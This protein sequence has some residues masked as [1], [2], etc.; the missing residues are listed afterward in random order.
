MILAIAH[1]IRPHHWI[2]NFFLFLPIFFAGGIFKNDKLWDTGM[3][4][5]LF[6]FT[7]SAIYVLN[8][9][10]DVKTDRLHPTKKG[11]PIASGKVPIP[12][13]YVLFAILLSGSV[14][15]SYML[16]HT[17]LYC[18]I[19]YLIINIAYTYGLKHVAILDLFLVSSGFL[20]RVI[21]GGFISEVP[22]SHWLIIMVLLL[23][24][25]LVLAKRRDDLIL[26][27]ENP[28][29]MRKSSSS[30]NL[31]FTNACLTMLSAVMIVAYIMYTVSDD[32]K[33]RLESD[34]LFYTCI[35]VIAGVMRYLQITLV[36]KKSGSPTRILFS[37][38]FI[39]VVIIGWMVSFYALIYII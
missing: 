12:L 28:T 33:M 24:L 9:I 29:L 17:F 11:R 4:F 5:I 1:L 20:L 37:D 23:S 7:A 14:F 39:V 25:F 38:G 2:K 8:D 18:I 19:A 35:F 34:Y 16:D 10:K 15:G 36:E 31:E 30:Y 3:G 21:G 22:V 13:A 32:V 26:A 27:L 6:S